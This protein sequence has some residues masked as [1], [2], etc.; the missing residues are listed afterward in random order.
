[1]HPLR[2]CL[3]VLLAAVGLYGVLA[4]FVAQRTPEIGVRMALGA[5]EG[6][7]AGLIVRV[8]GGPVLAGLFIGLIVSLAVT[9]SLSSLLYGV[10]PTDPITFGAVLFVMT[11]A[12]VIAMLLPARRALRVD[13]MTALRSE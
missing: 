10:E 4:Q 7:I 5:A 1:M 11:M 6:D 9:R 12:A 3:A 13:P 8:G 2:S